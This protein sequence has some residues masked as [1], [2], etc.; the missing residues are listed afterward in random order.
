[1]GYTHQDL[2]SLEGGIVVLC[3]LEKKELVGPE[4]G[5]TLLTG[6]QLYE[7]LSESELAL[8]SVSPSEASISQ[9]AF[10]DAWGN[11]IHAR[12]LRKGGEMH[13]VLWSD[14]PNRRNDSGKGDDIVLECD[15]EAPA[16]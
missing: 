1:M 16:R 14:G 7:R 9:R 8:S 2:K 10:C 12:V 4:D 15:I 5:E 11:K 6:S 3:G 13:V